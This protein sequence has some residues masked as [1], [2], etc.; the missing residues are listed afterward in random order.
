MNEGADSE[1]DFFAVTDGDGDDG[2][3]DDGKTTTMGDD[4]SN[5]KCARSCVCVRACACDEL[6]GVCVM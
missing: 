1:S 2:T 5:V 6:N 3:R 4:A